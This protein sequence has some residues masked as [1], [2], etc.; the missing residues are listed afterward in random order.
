MSLRFG[1][2]QVVMKA[3]LSGMPECKLGLN[4]KVV[5]DKDQGG[6]KGGGECT[7]ISYYHPSV[8]LSLCMCASIIIPLLLSLCMCASIIIPL[9]LSLCLLPVRACVRVRVCAS[10][11]ACMWNF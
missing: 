3:L 4:D 9:L 2:L 1:W 5:L 7:R 8:A 11:S 6:G 10:A